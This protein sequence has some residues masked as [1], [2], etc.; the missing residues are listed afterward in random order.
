MDQALRVL[1]LLIVGGAAVTA[2]AGAAAYWLEPM[3]RI[4]RA[5]RR[6]LE[7]KPD[8]FLASPVR[9]QGAGV[10]FDTRRLAIL[11][12][13]SDGGLLFELAELVGAELIFDGQVAARAMRGEPGRLLDRIDPEVSRVTV[14]LVFDD[15][16]EPEF[17]LDLWR[18]DDPPRPGWNGQ[19]AVQ[20]ARRFFARV[21]ALV[22]R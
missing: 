13:F 16:R 21:E 10:L 9:G 17:E 18:A 22:R 3:R 1:V 8:A 20:A 4:E 5:L 19:A 15:V 12:D 7:G 6:A 14:R 11:R 2:L